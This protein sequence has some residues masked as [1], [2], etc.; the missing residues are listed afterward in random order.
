MIQ[1]ELQ[2]KFLDDLNL[3][4]ERQE[5]AFE[6]LSDE[7]LE[8]MG[9]VPGRAVELFKLGQTFLVVDGDLD[10]LSRY[11]EVFEDDKIYGQVFSDARKK[12]DSR[13]IILCYKTERRLKQFL[14]TFLRWDRTSM[15]SS[16]GGEISCGRSCARECS[17]TPRSNNVPSNGD[18]R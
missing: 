16:S 17:T 2:E 1:L 11:P 10:K 6:N 5:K 15:S 13:K 9:V 3:Y 14:A 12:A 8:E 18:T 7:D 4:Y